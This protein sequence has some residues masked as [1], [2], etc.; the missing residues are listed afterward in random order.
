MSIFVLYCPSCIRACDNVLYVNLGYPKILEIPFTKY[1][2]IVESF[3]GVH[4][5]DVFYE[6]NSDLKNKIVQYKELKKGIAQKNSNKCI[7]IFDTMTSD[8]LLNY[9]YFNN[10]SD[11]ILHYIVAIL[12]PITT[13]NETFLLEIVKYIKQK[14]EKLITSKVINLIKRNG[15]DVAY[16]L[17]KPYRIDIH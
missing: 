8:E 9:S 4:I 12:Y 1:P 7:E 5:N 16:E 14:Q 17:V 11:N 13:E 6:Y 10:C 15:Y 2:I 3:D